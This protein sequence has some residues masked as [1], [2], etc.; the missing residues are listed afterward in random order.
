MQG[1]KW[2]YSEANDCI[3]SGTLEVDAHTTLMSLCG[4]LWFTFCFGF[5]VATTIRTGNLLGAGEHHKARVSGNRLQSQSLAGLGC[6]D[7]YH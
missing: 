4:I 2:K 3:T 1:P 6:H 5:G 7:L